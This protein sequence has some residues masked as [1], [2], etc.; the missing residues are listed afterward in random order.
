M[1]RSYN[2]TPMIVQAVTE[3]KLLKRAASKAVRRQ[4]LEEIGPGRHYARCFPQ[5][6]LKEYKSYENVGRSRL[7]RKVGGYRSDYFLPV[8]DARREQIKVA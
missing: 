7:Y 8:I 2:H 1:S 3:R 6:D 4:P 5:W